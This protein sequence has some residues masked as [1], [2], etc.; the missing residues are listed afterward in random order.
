VAVVETVA[1]LI[2]RALAEADG[3]GA[4][5]GAMTSP[6]RFRNLPYM[7]RRFVR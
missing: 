7:Q 2:N 4:G 3:E 1:R 5:R 6:E